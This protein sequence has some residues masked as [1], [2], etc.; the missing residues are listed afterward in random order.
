MHDVH[1]VVRISA[2]LTVDR[3]TLRTTLKP[4]STEVLPRLRALIALLDNLCHL[5]PM[6]TMM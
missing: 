2:S 5:H 3:M 4:P 6:Q 1:C